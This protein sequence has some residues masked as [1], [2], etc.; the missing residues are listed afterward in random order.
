MITSLWM[1]VI[2]WDYVLKNIVK[3]DIDTVC[4]SCPPCV[5]SGVIG[6]TCVYGGTSV[7]G[8]EGTLICC[9]D[10]VAEWSAVRATVA[11]RLDGITRGGT[12]RSSSMVYT[13]GTVQ[14][15]GVF[16]GSLVAQDVSTG[17]IK[18]DGLVPRLLPLCRC[19]Q[20]TR[21]SVGTLPGK[22][23]TFRGTSLRGGN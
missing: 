9:G 17:S 14:S 12:D 7:A 15:N 19:R 22:P 1:I 20:L 4:E 16:G 18:S 21:L 11:I 5:A 6:G 3:T 8:G 10:A 2:D 13:V 23:Y